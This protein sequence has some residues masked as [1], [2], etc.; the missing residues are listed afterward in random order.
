MAD[1][2]RIDS[3]K[4]TLFRQ[5]LDY[6]RAQPDPPA[7]PIGWTDENEGAVA[8][9]VVLRW[10]S[11][12]AVLADA[13]KPVWAEARTPRTSRICDSEMARINIEASAALAEWIDISRCGGRLECGTCPV[14][15]F[16][17]GGGVRRCGG[18]CDMP[19]GGSPCQVTCSSADAGT[20]VGVSC[21]GGGYTACGNPP[22]GC[23]GL[24]DC[25]PCGGD[26]GS[27]DAGGPDAGPDAGAD[28]G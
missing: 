8:A 16:C 18:T 1:A 13:A 3:G 15:Q 26:A 17:G 24:L 20:C 11:Y 25:G 9:A 21:I 14:S 4:I 27:V 5:V 12:V 10:G 28:G 23:G 22:N 7:P 19:D 2:A 6:L